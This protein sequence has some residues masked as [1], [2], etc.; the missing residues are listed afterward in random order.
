[1]YIN[2]A[3]KSAMLYIRHDF[4]NII[5]KIKHKLYIASRSAPSPK[6]KI[7]GAHLYCSA[8]RQINKQ[9]TNKISEICRKK[10]VICRSDA[11]IC[12]SDTDKF[13]LKRENYQPIFI[14]QAE[15]KPDET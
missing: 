15:L 2:A 5:F 13:C 6:K 10:M 1:V 11:L 8:I 7:L 4:Y 3:A 14:V 12:T 9:K